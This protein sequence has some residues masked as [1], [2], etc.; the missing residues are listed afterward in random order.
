VGEPPVEKVS[1]KGLATFLAHHEE[2]G[3]GFEVQRRQGSAGP[4]VRVVCGGC[5]KTIEYPAASDEGLS[6]ELPVSRASSER[7]TKRNP[8]RA[9]AGAG[10]PAAAPKRGPERGQRAGTG[11]PGAD[12]DAPRRR[13]SGARFIGWRSWLPGLIAGLIGGALVLIVLAIASDDGSSDGGS[14]PSAGSASRTTPT[15]P[16]SSAPTPAAKQRS[17]PQREEVRLERRQ[18]ADRVSIG[19][20]RGWSAGISGGAV[21]VIAGN[22]NAEVQV[23]YEPGEKSDTELAEAS[24]AFLLQRHPSARVTSVGPVDAGGVKARR[25]RVKYATGTETAVVLVAGGYSYLVLERL[26]KPSSGE[27]RRT[28][29]AVAMS[30]RPA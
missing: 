9:A 23:Y 27:V 14:T 26:G 7:P 8:R 19:V 13:E 2:C 28:T 10:K 11:A 29:A 24:K 30:F 4:I 20:P 22:G 17:R 3:G 18:L 16:T 1:R 12:A 15:A 25:V 5:G 21:T 6:M